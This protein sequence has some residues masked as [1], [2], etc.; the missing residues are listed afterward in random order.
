MSGVADFKTKAIELVKEAVAEDNAQ[1][2]EK[3]LQ[4]YLSALDYFSAHLKYDK[5]PASKAKITEKVRARRA[6][7][8]PLPAS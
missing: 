8:R 6:R 1:N 3:A 2:F 5:N 4:L 7:R